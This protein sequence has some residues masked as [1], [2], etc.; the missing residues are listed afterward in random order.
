MLADGEGGLVGVRACV[1]AFV[2]AF[3][4]ARVRRC[5][6][7]RACVCVCVCVCVW[8]CVRVCMCAC[9]F[10]PQNYLILM[11][12]FSS[13]AATKSMHFRSRYLSDNTTIGIGIFAI[14]RKWTKK[15]GKRLTRESN[16]ILLSPCCT[17][18]Y[19]HGRMQTAQL[20]RADGLLWRYL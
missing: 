4:R 6:S 12:T 11:R 2:G 13:A 9:V 14:G 10:K 19:A 1:R 16:V 17:P 3:S 5:L 18:M 7:A 15:G 20:L 8:V